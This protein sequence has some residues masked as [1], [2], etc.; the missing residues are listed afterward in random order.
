M[1]MPITS[2]DDIIIIEASYDDIMIMITK[3]Y[4]N[5]WW[6]L[7]REEVQMTTMILLEPV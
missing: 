5:V 6:L 2:N 7:V 4:I 1:A 3:H